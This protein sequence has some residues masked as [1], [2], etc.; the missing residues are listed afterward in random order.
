MY[1]PRKRSIDHKNSIFIIV[2]VV[3]VFVL[4]LCAL[5]FFLARHLRQRHF[6]PKYIPG[7][8]LKRK[9]KQWHPG[10]AS[11]GQVP[12]QG[13]ANREQDTAYQGAGA[14]NP[15]MTT[16]AGVQRE[17][18]IRSIITLPAYSPSPKPTEQII[19]REGEREGMDMVVEFPE[20]SEEQEARREDQ[21]ESLY[22]IRLQR[23]QELADR[24]ARRQ[25][26]RSA[27]AR[28]DSVR[29]EE[30]AAESRAR[31]TRR[32]QPSS[33]NTS[34]SAATAIAEHQSR[35][36]DRRISSVS[37]ASIGHV[38]HDGSRL[39]ADS[40]ESDHQ[41]LLEN[42]AVNASSPSL[43]DRQSTSYRSRVESL[44]SSIMTTDTGGTDSDP[45]ILGPTS[46]RGSSRPVS[47]AEEDLG[48]LNI[49]PPPEYEHLD[50]GDAPAYESP[51]RGRTDEPR[52]L[53]S[54]LTTLPSIHVDV[55][56]PIAVT[57]VTPTEP[58]HPESEDEH[59]TTP[60]GPI[61]TSVVSEVDSGSTSEHTP[62]S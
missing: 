11:Y 12:S 35:E 53:S 14:T 15:E 23:R 39:R 52:Q 13:A 28:G 36:R 46:T 60:R 44:A 8:Y 24:E 26:R 20:T 33:S 4:A 58:R 62:V 30:L 29:L 19:G 37:Y 55:A 10:S 56:S 49:Q 18:S 9:W 6:E 48:T 1:I 32:H 25:E 34:L 40:H 61:R 17:T 7:K 41:P 43:T 42:A 38:R 45:L 22:Q 21:M 3:I 57:P 47:Q 2:F 31:S 51:T 59:D 54:V 27:R 5:G 50:W 16:T